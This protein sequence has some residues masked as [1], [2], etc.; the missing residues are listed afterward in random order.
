MGTLV[1]DDLVDDPRVGEVREAPGDPSRG[2][3][4]TNRTPPPAADPRD[5]QRVDRDDSRRRRQSAP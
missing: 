3:D 1:Y 5:H 2:G 4:E